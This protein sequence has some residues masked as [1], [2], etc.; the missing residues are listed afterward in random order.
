[1]QDPGVLSVKTIYAYFKRYGYAT[2]I[3]A[4]SFRNVGEIRELA[5]CD[6]ITI[7]PALLQQLEDSTG[8]LPYALWPGLAATCEPPQLRF[9]R[10]AA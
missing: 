3:M 6:A 4:A 2:T 1:M 9:D 7:A 8:P 10:C 5:G